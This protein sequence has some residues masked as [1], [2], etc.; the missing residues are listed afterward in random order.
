V[1]KGLRLVIGVCSLLAIIG[2]L[3]TWFLVD[4]KPHASLTH[5]DSEWGS[6][7][8]DT[9][10][11]NNSTCELTKVTTNRDSDNQA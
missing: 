3:W 7:V 10:E 5:A 8:G 1:D 6:E 4:D 9:E 2:V 11:D